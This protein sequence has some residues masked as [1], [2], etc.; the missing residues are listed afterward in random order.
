MSPEKFDEILVKIEK[1]IKALPNTANGYYVVQNRLISNVR[2]MFAAAR[3]IMT[4]NTSV[5][6]DLVNA[7]WSDLSDKCQVNLEIDKE[8]YVKLQHMKGFKTELR[9]ET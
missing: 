9:F 2:K 1:D 6:C 3:P 5:R 4:M 7:S 8:D